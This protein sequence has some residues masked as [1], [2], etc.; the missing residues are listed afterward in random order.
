MALSWVRSMTVASE[1][2]SK[3]Q[4]DFESLVNITTA[5]C[6]ELNKLI[7][8]SHELNYPEFKVQEFDTGSYYRWIG[9]SCGRMKFM[10]ELVT[11][12]QDY[13]IAASGVCPEGLEWSR[14]YYSYPK[15]LKR[16]WKDSTSPTK[17]ARE[18]LGDIVSTYAEWCYRQI[19]VQ[20]DRLK[21]IA[22]NR[23]KSGE[24]LD[25]FAWFKDHG[26][27]LEMSQFKGGDSVKRG[28]IRLNVDCE[29]G[30]TKLQ[31]D[32]LSIEDLEV[33]LG[34]LLS[35]RKSQGVEV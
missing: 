8:A 30:S 9:V 23:K 14:I 29:S 34:A 21:K 11:S 1:Y 16:T 6:C 5:V 35:C 18:F 22:D 25:Y 2:I 33:M 31:C 12:K 3:S 19:E 17:I 26:T 28:Y 7:A 15:G 13:R 10:F 20:D 4:L 32:Y 24:L 27:S